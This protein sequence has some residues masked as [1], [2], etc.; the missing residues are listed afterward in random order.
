ML[1]DYVSLYHVVCYRQFSLALSLFYSLPLTLHFLCALVALPNLTLCVCNVDFIIFN[2]TQFKFVK[3]WTRS[4]ASHSTPSDVAKFHS[5]IHFV[6]HNFMYAHY[7]HTTLRTSVVHRYLYLHKYVHF[8]LHY[9]CICVGILCTCVSANVIFAC[10]CVFEFVWVG[11][12]SFNWI[13]L[14]NFPCQN[15]FV[16][17]CICL[18]VPQ[19]VGGQQWE[20]SRHFIE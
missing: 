10:L 9:M 1:C 5:P 19:S 4:S 6:N 2:R 11:I 7:I 17:A 8:Y 20:N 14:K 16:C 18:Y 12:G 13:K 3:K 15:M